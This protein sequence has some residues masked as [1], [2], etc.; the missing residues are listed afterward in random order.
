MSKNN[1]I[2]PI[3]L[4]AGAAVM[5]M[6]G[7]KK[8]SSSGGSSSA[9]SDWS[10]ES[11]KKFPEG[12]TVNQVRERICY[13]WNAPAGGMKAGVWRQIDYIDADDYHF[14]TNNG[15]ANQVRTADLFPVMGTKSG[16]L[17]EYY[18]LS[19][20]KASMAWSTEERNNVDPGSLD[21]S[22]TEINNNE[23]WRPI[24]DEISSWLGS[25][26]N[27]SDSSKVMVNREIVRFMA[28]VVKKAVAV[29]DANETIDFYS[30][31]EWYCKGGGA[32]LSFSSDFSSNPDE[33]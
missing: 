13:I 17:E 31:S 26:D 2:I 8:K 9:S 33:G 27:L 29:L 6:G 18:N 14:V 15:T 12:V 22:D 32:K 24:F 3:A 20:G 1:S 23:V 5:L 28:Y 11:N 21:W 25:R 7:K 19:L 16:T 4:A 30:G 10:P